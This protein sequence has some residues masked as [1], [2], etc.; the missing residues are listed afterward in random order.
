M[1]V[2]IFALD[3]PGFAAELAER[4]AVV[5]GAPPL[6]LVFLLVERPSDLR[7]LSDLRRLLRPEGAI[8]VLRTKGNSRTVAD[9]DIIEAGKRHG[10]VDNKIAS[11]SDALSA[12]RLVIPTARRRHDGGE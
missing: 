11:F 7:A 6:D 1:A 2:R 3:D 8:W 9:I 10:L 12:T 5:P 4:G